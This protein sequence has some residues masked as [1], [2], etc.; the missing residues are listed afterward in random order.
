MYSA[1]SEMIL[2]SSLDAAF[3]ET[4][5]QLVRAGR[6]KTEKNWR[7]RAAP[8]NCQ[9]VD[10]VI[11]RKGNHSFPSEFVLCVFLQQQSNRITNQN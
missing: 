10:A 5:G 4:Q 1:C 2:G 9:D 6:S 11:S 3:S 7:L 8:T